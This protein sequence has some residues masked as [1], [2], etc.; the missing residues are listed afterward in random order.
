MKF[1]KFVQDLAWTKD[2]FLQHERRQNI[3]KQL[4]KYFDPEDLKLANTMG[5]PTL[6][7]PLWIGRSQQSLKKKWKGKLVKALRDILSQPPK[8]MMTTQSE[9]P[10]VSM[11]KHV[12]KLEDQ[13]TDVTPLEKVREVPEHCVEPEFFPPIKI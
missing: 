8:H 10:S 11:Y 6:T 12:P 5:D 13:M 9:P 3:F 4:E 7:I 2:L 1:D